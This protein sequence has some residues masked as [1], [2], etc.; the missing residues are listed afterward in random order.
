V[1]EV[2]SDLGRLERDDF[3]ATLVRHESGAFVLPAPAH[4]GEWLSVSPEKLASL[5]EYAGEMFDYVVIDTPGA[6]NDAVA[7]ALELAD[8][9]F[10]V[11]S[12]EVTSVKNTAMLLEVLATAGYPA[13][14]TLVV[15]NHTIAEP[16]VTVVDI[17]PTLGRDSVWEVPY[18]ANVRR[19]SQAG[20]PVVLLDPKSLGGKSLRALANR[21]ATQPDGID[22][23]S[24]VREPARRGDA[25]IGSRL[26]EAMRRLAS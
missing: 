1:A 7:A 26:R 20:H 24:S 10:I 2:A 12:M 6:F 21:I 9:A 18:D 14:R 13:E 11:T 17:A 5:V 4:V 25:I 19:S 3:K 16:G 22:R 23:R 15:V 8:H